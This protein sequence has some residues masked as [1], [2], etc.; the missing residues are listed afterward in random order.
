MFCTGVKQLDLCLKQCSL[1]SGGGKIGS[2]YGEEEMVASG[3]G[4]SCCGPELRLCQWGYGGGPRQ[5]LFKT[6]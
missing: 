5:D 4:L 1:R 2:N 6:Y 3:V